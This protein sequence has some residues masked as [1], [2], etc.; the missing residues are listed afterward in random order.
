MWKLTAFVLISCILIYISRASLQVRG[1]H[2]F[3]RLLAWE[4]IL[5]L[6]ILNIDA[7]FR[8]PFSWNQIIS[9]ILLGASLVPLVLG[10]SALRKYGKPAEKRE[11][12]SNLLAFEKTTCLVSCGIFGIIRHPLYSSLLLL[13]W[14]VFF[15]APSWFGGILVFFATT[16]LFMTARADEKECIRFFGEEYRQYMQKTRRFIPLLF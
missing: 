1:S 7:W 10:I 6:F 4:Y 8:E 12:E 2:G 16:S 3:F 9:W 11:G 15:K 14:G 5:V 13:A